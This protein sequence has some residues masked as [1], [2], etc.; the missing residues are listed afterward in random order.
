M[1]KRLTADDILPLVAGLSAHERMRLLRIL[2]EAPATGDSA[3]YIAAPPQVDEFVSDDE[4]LAW[5]ADG[6]EEFG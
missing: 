4:P 2:A 1:A 5:D 6:W 3:A